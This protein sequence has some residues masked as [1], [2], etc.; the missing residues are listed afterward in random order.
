MTV[1]G[2]LTTTLGA[3]EGGRSGFVQ[4]DSAGIGLYLDAAV[5]TALP[6]GT[7][8]RM[9]GILG[10]RYQQRVLRV[11]EADIVTGPIADMPIP[12]AVTTGA[13]DETL[14]GTRVAVTGAI[15]G[16]P[17]A[18]ADGLG[19]DIDDGSGPVRAVVGADALAGRTIG[20]GDV[21]TATGPL[22]Q[23]DSSGTGTAG[24]R[25]YPTLPGELDIATPAPTP[26]PTPSTTPAPTPT[27]IPTP[28]PA[29]TPTPTPAP[30]PTASPT[31]TTLTPVAA[32]AYPVGAWVAIRAT[33][34]AE[35]GRLGTPR[36]FA[37]G[38]DTG[39]I[40]VR[41]PADEAGPSRGTSVLVFG[42]LAAPYGQLEVR[43]NA[44][45]IDPLGIESVPAPWPL[46]PAGPDESTEGRLVSTGGRLLAKPTRSTGGDLTFRFERPDG[47]RFTVQS[48]VSSGISAASFQ[49]NATYGIVGI[50]GQ[51]ASRKGALDGYRIWARDRSDVTL[52]AA[53]PARGASATPTPSATKGAA[54]VN[55]IAQALRVTDRL[56]TI[57]ATVTAAT[58]LLDATGRRI[59]VQDATG[60]VEVLLPTGSGHPAVGSRLRLEGR[61]GTAYGSPRLRATNVDRIAAAAPIVPLRLFAAPTPAH[62]WR[63]VTITGRIGEVHKLG[64]RWR[65]DLVVGGGQIPIVGQPGAGIPFDRMIAGRIASITG[66]VRAAYPS[67]ADRRASI[68]PRSPAD[69]Q[70]GPA[71]GSSS[72]AAST[73][74][75]GGAAGPTASG[76][77]SSDG[78]S[79][80]SVPDLDLDQLAG[81]EGRVVRVGGLVV[82][83]GPDRFRIDDGTALGTIV[84]TG[85]AQ[86]LLA[87]V[88]PGDA[89]NVTG[90]VVRTDDGWA[91][92]TSDPAALSRA[93]DPVAADPATAGAT[94]GSASSAAPAGPVG[95]FSLA[96]FDLPGTGAAGAAGL[97]MLALTTLGSLVVTLAIRRRRSRTAFSKRIATRLAAIGE[98]APSPPNPSP[99]AA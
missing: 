45:G 52:R 33:V 36:L 13:I 54:T 55:S 92:S 1:A 64:D 82:D 23:R 26:T 12:R 28:T 97:S 84:L 7:S 24:Y 16:A 74:S 49:V 70:V 21:V 65:A 11:A 40:A 59:V 29:P 85:Q 6:A 60:A 76:A 8:V 19:I 22:G 61:M 81:S 32:R 4:D 50:S 47:S 99:P 2:T 56:V 17:D 86:E 66:I 38:D 31:P 69:V 58:A 5:V 9:T 94:D 89:V 3:L 91:V 80:A 98:G 44:G 42:Q 71:T 18:L 95:T 96:G 72:G 25:I 68:L 51:R 43:P 62:L 37:I 30:T 10:T 67:A 93:G 75:T 77:P 46:G 57:E 53:A 48:D 34:T 88:E 78:P 20:S 27:P 79:G 15:I 73:A 35:A 39:G 14:E 90:T 63:L 87:L 83:L 41:L